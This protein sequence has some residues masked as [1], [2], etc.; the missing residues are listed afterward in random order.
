[1]GQQVM[2]IRL[3]RVADIYLKRARVS[4]R[5]RLTTVLGVSSTSGV[6]NSDEIDSDVNPTRDDRRDGW[7]FQTL[8]IPSG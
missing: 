6:R 8:E 5:A 4:P 7:A 1:M 3:W 2:S